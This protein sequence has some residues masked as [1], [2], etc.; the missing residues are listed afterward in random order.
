[1]EIILTIT[2]GLIAFAIAVVILISIV[3]FVYNLGVQ[4]RIYKELM[5]SFKDDDDFKDLF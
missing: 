4:H 1:M 3:T 5:K 2:L